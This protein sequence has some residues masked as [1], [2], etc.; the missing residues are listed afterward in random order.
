M[1]SQNYRRTSLPIW[2][3]KMHYYLGRAY[4]G[5]ENYQLALDQYEYFLKIWND[6]DWPIKEI[7]DTRE[8]LAKLKSRS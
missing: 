6:T 3:A 8:R 5:L 4:E 7:E 2:N 1:K